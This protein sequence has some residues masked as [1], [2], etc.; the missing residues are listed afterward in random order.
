MKNL[1]RALALSAVLA[2]TALSTS[3]A[4]P[5]GTCRTFCY[6]SSGLPTSVTWGATR[7]DCCEG[8]RTPP[9]PPGTTP[10][11]ISWNNLRCGV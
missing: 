2:L 5:L 4:A 10:R 3:S 9:C 6:G 7:E 8:T 11:T 1:L